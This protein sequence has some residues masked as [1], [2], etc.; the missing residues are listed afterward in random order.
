MW[1]PVT[2]TDSEA[3]KRK[4]HSEGKKELGKKKNKVKAAMM[5]KEY[6]VKL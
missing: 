4:L 3:R 5:K 1:V 6:T 2:G